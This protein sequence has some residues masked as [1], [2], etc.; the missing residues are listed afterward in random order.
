MSANTLKT[1]LAAVAA[2]LFAGTFATAALAQDAEG[3]TQLTGTLKK[4]K[5]NKTIVIGYRDASVPFSYLNPAGQ[6]IGYSID[7]CKEIV[8]DIRAELGDDTIQ[9]KYAPVDTQTRI[10]SV[11]DG[12]V[13]LECGTTTNNT[14][15]QKQVA[16]SPIIFVSGTKLAVKRSSKFRSYRDLKGRTVAVTPASTNEAAIKALNNKQGLNIAIKVV[17]GNA[18]AFEAVAAGQ[19]D[20]WAGDDAVLFAAIA[21]S[22]NPR[23]FMV[24]D[25]FVSYDPYG[26]MFR[27]NDPDFGALVKRTFERLA[28][29]RELARIYE[30]WFQRRLPSGRTL[31]I[32]MSPQLESIFESLGQPTE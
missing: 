31:G 29:A 6:P 16:F 3:I 8:E 9:V 23:E 11:V 13:D 20:A 27:K 32:E 21:E 12:T 26:L 19:A 4:I 24:L 2:C 17:P 14:E 10:P 22:K 7:I 15:R 1:L 5:A 30:Q 28:E 25:E 18:Q